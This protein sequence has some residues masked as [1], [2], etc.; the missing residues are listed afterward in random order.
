ML[1]KMDMLGCLLR[2]QVRIKPQ[3]SKLEVDLVV[4]T[5]NENYDED[6]EHHLKI[7]KQ[8]SLFIR[9]GC[10]ALGTVGESF[11]PCFSQ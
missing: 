10:Y 7:S 8:V 6:R 5:N 9:S 11:T 1:S 2:L 3:Q 4:D